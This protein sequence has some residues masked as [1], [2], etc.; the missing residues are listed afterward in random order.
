MLRNWEKYAQ[1]NTYQ[2][3]GEISVPTQTPQL[4]NPFPKS[5]SIAISALWQGKQEETSIN[6]SNVGS[7][8][9]VLSYMVIQVFTYRQY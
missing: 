7:H 8:I 9:Q 2:S 4:Q 3:I 5:I 6:I 1:S